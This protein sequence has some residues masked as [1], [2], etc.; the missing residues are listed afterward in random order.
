MATKLIPALLN[1]LSF[2]SVGT[3]PETFDILLCKVSLLL[4]GL[5]EIN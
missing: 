5:V 3:V 4:L 1:E 2:C